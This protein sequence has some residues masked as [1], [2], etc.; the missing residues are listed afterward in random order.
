MHGGSADVRSPELI[1]FHLRMTLTSRMI[2]TSRGTFH[3][4]R[5]GVPGAP[6]LLLLHGWPQSSYCWQ[7]VARALADRFDLVMPDLRGLGDSPRTLEPLAYT[8]QALAG[9]VLAVMETLAIERCTLIGHDWGGAVAQELAFAAPGRIQRL[10]L[11]N[12]LVLANSRGNRAARA[13]LAAVGNRPMWYQ[14]FQHANGLP[15]AMIPGNEAAWLGYFLKT[16]SRSG[17]PA[18][19]FDEYVRCYAIEHT[20]ATGAAY[21]RCHKAD[22]ARWRELAGRRLTMPALYIHGRHDPVIVS[23]FTHHLDDVFEDIRLETLD[24]A[25]FVAEECPDA[26]ARLIGCF[27]EGG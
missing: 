3:V 22:S 19:A 21:Y 13:A 4:R 12:I 8:K 18:A 1:E 15:E 24:A 20:P 14:F 9:D 10:V 23:E 7:P 26:V 5:A 6:V 11:L 2:E 27:A 16:W 17:F 25:H